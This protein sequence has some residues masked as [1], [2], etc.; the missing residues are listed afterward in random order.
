[1][2]G[3]KGPGGGADALGNAGIHKL[4]GGIAHPSGV[5]GATGAAQGRRRGGG[6]R[7]CNNLDTET[8]A[9]CDTP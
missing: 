4:R 6:G 5:S 1:M 3:K 8:A 2:F 9:G 7:H